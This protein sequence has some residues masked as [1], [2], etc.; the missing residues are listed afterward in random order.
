MIDLQEKVDEIN[1]RVKQMDEDLVSLI[2]SKLEELEQ[3]ISRIED[4]LK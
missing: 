3:S 1:E 4:K 2:I